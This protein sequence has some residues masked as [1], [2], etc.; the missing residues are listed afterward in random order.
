M[1][2]PRLIDRQTIEEELG[3]NRRAAEKIMRAIPKVEL[4]GF[5]RIYVYRA[6]VERYVKE[7][8]RVS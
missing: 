6:D 3:I 7:N 8:T 4:P 1:T 5:R 2:L